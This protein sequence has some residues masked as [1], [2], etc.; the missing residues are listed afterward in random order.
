MLVH[1]RMTDDRKEYFLKKNKILQDFE[2]KTIR[3]QLH[4]I[5]EDKRGKTNAIQQ[6]EKI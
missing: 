5:F 2:S 1:E 4:K 3:S 6:N